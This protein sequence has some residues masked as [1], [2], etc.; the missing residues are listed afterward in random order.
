MK[1]VCKSNIFN[2]QKYLLGANQMLLLS[3]FMHFAW[4][5]ITHQS[6]KAFFNSQSPQKSTH[7]MLHNDSY[8]YTYFRDVCNN[9]WPYYLFYTRIKVSNMLSPYTL[10]R[11][12]TGPFWFAFSGLA[13]LEH[14]ENTLWNKTDL[15]REFMF[16]SFS[17]L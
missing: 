13:I 11:L 4:V 6:T 17:F 16:L 2:C 9:S 15:I 12:W 3:N 7:P 14:H 10:L 5:G 8:I 1:I